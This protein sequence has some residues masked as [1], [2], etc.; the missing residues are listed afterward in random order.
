MLDSGAV[1]DAEGIDDA[2][3]VLHEI[4]ESVASGEQNR[5]LLSLFLKNK[6]K[7]FNY[8]SIMQ[9]FVGRRLF[10]VH[11]QTTPTKLLRWRRSVQHCSFREAK[12]FAR[13]F[14]ERRTR[15]FS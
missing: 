1:P 11:Q 6:P 7:M 9:R 2:F 13:L 12:V 10:R 8:S 4:G 3:E 14:S 15:L 5:L